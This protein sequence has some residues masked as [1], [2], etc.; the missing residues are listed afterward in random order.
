MSM[1]SNPHVL[2]LAAGASRRFGSPK[3]LVRIGG[4]PLLHRAVSQATQ[5][6]G[7]AVTVVLGAHASELAPLLKHTTAS[8]VINRQWE[9]GLASSLRAGIASLPG[10]CE[11]VL[12]TLADQVAVTTLDLQ[13]LAGAW[14]RQPDWL[15]AASYAGHTGVPAVFPHHTFSDFGML[16]G[17]AGARAL[18]MRHSDR[19][20]RIPMP[21]AAIDL[22]TPEDLLQIERG[23]DQGST[24]SSS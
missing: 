24:P 22:D 7:H 21:N 2:V 17:D 19:C 18:L 15:I 5:V 20:L 23:N 16:R 3:Q 13:R 12:V 9:E 4:Q 6:A 14:R 1:D 11:A 10:S 8:V